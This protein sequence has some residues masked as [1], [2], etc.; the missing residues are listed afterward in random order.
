[1]IIAIIGIGAERVTNVL[2]YI[3]RDYRD[4]VVN[5]EILDEEEW[6][7]IN[8][9][10]RELKNLGYPF[11]D[12]LIFLMSSRVPAETLENYIKTVKKRFI[13]MVKITPPVPDLLRG[14]TLYIKHCAN[15]HGE[16]GR[17]NTQLAEML[18]PKPRVLYRNGDLS[19]L[20]VFQSM[21]GIEGTAMPSFENLPEKDRWDI[22]FFVLSLGRDTSSAIFPLSVSQILTLNDRELIEYL[23]SMGIEDPEKYVNSLRTYP[24][25]YLSQKPKDKLLRYLEMAGILTKSGKFDE[26][27]KLLFEAYFEGFEP[28]EG[29]L[30][31]G[32]V[33][34]IELRFNEVRNMLERGDLRAY[35]EIMELKG[36][37]SNLNDF[38]PFVGFLGS[39]GIIFREG[40][41]AILIIAAIL[42]VLSAFG[43][44]R[45]RIF[46]HLG[47]ISAIIVGIIL[48]FS[49][50]AI[51]NFSGFT[52]E[53]VEGISSILAS[54]VL[55]YVGHWLFSNADAKRWKDYIKSSVAKSLKG[56][57]RLGLFGLSFI[58]VFREV[59][60]TVLFYQALLVQME[61]PIPI[62]FGFLVG[63]IALFLVAWSIFYLKR[64]LPLTQFF[65]LSGIL[66]LMLSFILVGKGIRA[67]QEAD[68]LP[69]TFVPWIP[70]FSALGIYPYAE[71][72]L[73]QMILLLAVFGVFVVSFY[74]EM[75]KRE[76][77]LNKV[78]SFEAELREIY[79]SLENVRCGI[80][81][82]ILENHV[83]NVRESLKELEE[84]IVVIKDKLSS[85]LIIPNDDGEKARMAKS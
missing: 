5:G 50:Q 75:R 63:L 1:M 43:Y 31:S 4:I 32:K 40:L 16:D 46:F 70:E 33:R 23:T 66:L 79:Q 49:A 61:N 8:S 55:F 30:P 67:F 10:A 21:Y 62:I 2:D 28:L 65:T 11:A 25:A 42:A 56:S 34:K 72:A 76:E 41:E 15:C 53:F 48:W 52:R 26:A 81:A 29:V 3:A 51:I 36:E 9:F 82:C 85:F 57:Y 20:N 19:L 24:Q 83:E 77:I 22:T 45:E 17:S 6:E 59:I 71:T 14:K 80:G 44:K 35:N 37:V 27:K 64:R 58:A 69:T 73:A 38:N 18:D 12:T 7:E 84:E 60:E 39:F 13:G 68:I 54:V 74:G 78:S 47:W